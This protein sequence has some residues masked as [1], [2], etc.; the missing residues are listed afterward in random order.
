[1]IEFSNSRHSQATATTSTP[2]SV[3]LPDRLSVPP[4]SSNDEDALSPH[5]R[6]DD[7]LEPPSQQQRLASAAAA[8]NP[9][10]PPVSISP[11]PSNEGLSDHSWRESPRRSAF[12]SWEKQ[13][14]REDSPSLMSST[15]PPVKHR[16]G[17]P[18]K[19]MARLN[20]H[21]LGPRSPVCRHNCGCYSHTRRFDGPWSSPKGS[22]TS[23]MVHERLANRHPRCTIECPGS[24]RIS[25]AARDTLIPK[26]TDGDHERY[27]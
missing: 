19:A 9:D 6:E 2:T 11:S 8:A 7:S 22:A 13:D 18:S 1:M 26:Q 3:R 20:A 12:S 17:R 21:P 25:I 10:H 16:G 4:L 5:S 23:R 15:P 27:M 14:V 24:H